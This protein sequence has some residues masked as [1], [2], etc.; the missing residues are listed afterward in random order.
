MQSQATVIF[1]HLPFLHLKKKNQQAN[2]FFT[3]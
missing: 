2:P 1:T 3:R